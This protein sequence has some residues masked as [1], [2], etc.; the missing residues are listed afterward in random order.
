VQEFSGQCPV[1]G[2]D[3]FGDSSVLWPELVAEWRLTEHEVE[4]MNRQQGFHCMECG[5]NLRAMALAHAILATHGN[6]HKTLTDFCCA[7]LKISI[8]EINRAGNLTSV[9]RRA[10]GHQLVEF[11]QFD[12]QALNLKSERYDL[13]LHSDT[14]EHVASPVRG[15]EECYRI[16]KPGGACIFTVPIIVGRLSKTREG[17]TPSYHGGPNTSD[18]DQIVRTEFGADIWTTVLEAGFRNCTIHALEF[19]AAL[20]VIAKKF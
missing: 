20:A 1:C 17:L 7:D 16:L 8:L 19:P 6:V 9:L 15:M 2:G 12:M 11:P 5:N 10:S 4:Y 13:V 3:T 18:S 14:L